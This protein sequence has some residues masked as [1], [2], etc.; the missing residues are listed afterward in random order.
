[1]SNLVIPSVE[2]HCIIKFP[3]KEKMKPAEILPRLTA[4][5]GEQTLSCA[6][7]YDW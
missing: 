1:M 2:Q 7:I 6:N 5:Y 3:M 4:Q